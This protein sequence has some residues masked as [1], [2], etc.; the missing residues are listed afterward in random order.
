MTDLVKNHSRQF[1]IKSL[2]ISRIVGGARQNTNKYSQQPILQLHNKGND[3]IV[4]ASKAFLDGFFAFI[5]NWM[6]QYSQN[7]EQRGFS[8]PG[9][10]SSYESPAKK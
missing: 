2:Q 6:T 1:G 4:T 7:L 5:K 9:D 8:L 3:K 10:E